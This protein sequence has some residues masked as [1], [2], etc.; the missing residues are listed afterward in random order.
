MFTFKLYFLE[1]QDNKMQVSHILIYTIV[2]KI[3]IFTFIYLFDFTYLC[4]GKENTKICRFKNEWFAGDK[5]LPKFRMQENVV[6]C[7]VEG[8]R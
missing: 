7:H 2:D 1:L 6:D 4:A 3:Y 5:L 8:S